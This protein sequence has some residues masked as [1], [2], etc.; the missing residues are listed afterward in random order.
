[1]NINLKNLIILLPILCMMHLS[2]SNTSTEDEKISEHID[3]SWKYKAG[4]G[5]DSLWSSTIYNDSAWIP[6]SSLKTLAAQNLKTENG[7]GWYRKS[8]SLSDSLMTAIEKS[9]TAVFD[10]GKFAACDEVYLNGKLIGKTGQFPDDYMGNFDNDRTYFASKDVF[11]KSGKNQIAIKFHDGWSS[12]GGFL[13]QNLVRISSA[14]TDQK[15]NLNVDVLDEDN[16]F[17]G[18]PIRIKANIENNNNQPVNGYLCVT[19]TTDDY[20]FIQADTVPFDIAKR[21]SLSKEFTQNQ[22]DAGFYRYNVSIL[23]NNNLIQEK[24]FNI[25]YDPEKI[26]SP[27]DSKDDFKDFWNNN[28]KELA[29]VSPKYKLTPILDASKLDYDMYLVEMYS[30]G[31]ELIRGYYAK[32]K[33]GENHPVIVEYMGYGSSPYYPNQTWDGF[34]YFVLSIRGQALNQPSNKYGTWINS[35]LE[36]KD[37]YYYKGAYMDV[38]RAID[39]VCSRPEIDSNK[40]AVRGASQGGALSFVAA[41]LDKRIKVA[42]PSIPFLSDF[43][44]YFK[45]APWPK[46]DIDSYMAE[47]PNAKW[48]DIYGVLSYFDIKNLAPWIECPLIMGVGVQDNVC[49]PHTNFAAYNQVTSPKRWIAFADYGHSVGKYFGD[50]SMNLFRETLNVTKP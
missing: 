45:I 23:R 29:K 48:E 9:G 25:G 2:C 43:P 8:F 50:Q 33:T 11:N 5:I 31:D 21:S 46:S 17:I 40:I 1:M 37:N 32:P 44:D 22:P 4:V 39:F 3:E 34:A 7:F 41:A 10:F 30:L 19:L 47:H 27:I 36:D 26:N 24:K 15:I 20:Q 42:A 16:I 12:A 14:S 38:I 18:E 28:L 35:G 49:P 6:V 13:D